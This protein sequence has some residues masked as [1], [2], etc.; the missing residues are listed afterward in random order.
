[1]RRLG[2]REVF[3]RQ[4]LIKRMLKIIPRVVSVNDIDQTANTYNLNA[5]NEALIKL[6]KPDLS[7]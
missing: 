7:N 1:M 3:S 4:F 6:A 5:R 2:R